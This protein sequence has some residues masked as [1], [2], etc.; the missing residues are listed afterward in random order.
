MARTSTFAMLLLLT[1]VPLKAAYVCQAGQYLSTDHTGQPACL[2]CPAGTFMSTGNHVNTACVP[3]SK[4]DHYQY[5]VRLKDC[6]TTQDAE[7]GCIK[8]HYRVEV[9]F[10][11]FVDG[12]CNRCTECRL[13]NLFEARPCDETTDAVC[14]PKPGMAVEK[15][16]FDRFKCVDETS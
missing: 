15:D 16:K 4:P 13:L 9:K 10:Q 2:P 1:A 6:S 3:C 11:D 7:I 12:E 8:D 14:C 5:E